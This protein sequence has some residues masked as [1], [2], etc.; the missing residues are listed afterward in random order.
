MTM[1][2]KMTQTERRAVISLSSIMSLRML[3]LFMVCPVFSL[4]A[5]KLN[6]ATPLLIGIA[7]SIYGLA[8]ALC[9]IPFGLLSDYFGRKPI[10]YMGLIIFLLGSA[11]CAEA[12]SIYWMIVGRVLQ[13][14]GAVGSTILAMLADLTTEAQRTKAMAINGITIG[15][16]FIIAMILGPLLVFF[17]AI[18]DL[19][20]L[21]CAMSLLAILILFQWVP[22]APPHA[23]IQ[24][25]RD[26]ILARKTWRASLLFEPEL[27]KLNIGIFLL[28]A[29]FTASFIVIPIQ[30]NR[31]LNFLVQLQW[32]IY[33]PILI[34]ASIIALFCI[35]IA[36]KKQQI[37][38][39]FIMGIFMLLFAESLLSITK[40]NFSLVMLGLCLFFSGFSLLEALLPSLV[41]RIAP[42]QYKGSALGIYSCSQFLG[43]FV[44]GTIAGYLF[45]QFNV[46]IVYVFC[47]ML[48]S[49]WLILA[50]LM[51]PPQLK[52]IYESDI[53]MI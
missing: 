22:G 30:L 39:Y 34:I 50:F 5:S 18:Q 44:G 31:D 53:N 27:A 13:G 52:V 24:T 38:F 3:G 16:T 7:M 41:S 21:S 15:A 26:S 11:I 4:Y 6:S 45:G 33:L 40:T 42:P 46:S 8:Q 1:T 36:E 9:Q 43:I 14:A 37:K 2:Q 28:H 12:H 29:I 19:F 49:L 10:I 35:A 20:F 17:F 48:A 47:A 32:M 25:E 23:E 51:R